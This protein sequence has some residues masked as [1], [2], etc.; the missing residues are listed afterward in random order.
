MDALLIKNNKIYL[1]GIQIFNYYYACLI[2]LI[3]IFIFG[4][5]L[6][7]STVTGSNKDFLGLP[8]L[9]ELGL[10][11]SITVS[12]FLW[13]SLKIKLRLQTLK[14]KLAWNQLYQ[15]IKNNTK[16]D[17]IYLDKEQLT[18]SIS[19]YK[20]NF[21]L[22]EEMIVIINK[23]D[24]FDFTQ[25]NSPNETNALPW[26]ISSNIKKLNSIIN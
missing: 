11:T 13:M 10:L 18:I 21:L 25:L 24:S 17:I 8:Y 1:K 4:F 19:D 3:P 5:H 22:R 9:S 20:N 6:L 12:F 15:T 7:F 26:V 14:T 23:E 2:L 16:W